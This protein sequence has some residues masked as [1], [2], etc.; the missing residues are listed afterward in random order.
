MLLTVWALSSCEKENPVEKQAENIETYIKTKRNRNPGMK[1]LQEGDVYYLYT[2]GDSTTTVSPG[3]SVYF[4]YLATLVADTV[5]YFDT[6]HRETAE[7]LRLN[8][9]YKSFEPLGAV[10]GNNNLLPGLN[11]GL[12]LI[13]PRDNGEIIFN[14]DLGFGD[15]ANGIV[16][17]FSA[18]IFKVVILD[19]KRNQNS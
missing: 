14:S 11:I 7:A 17:P 15:K 2:P 3:D 6:N 8:T 9:G 1:L 18:L 13:H 10:V 12:K 16:P 4:Y 5:R 19:V